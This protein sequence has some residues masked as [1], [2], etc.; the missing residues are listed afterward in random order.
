MNYTGTG[1]LLRLALRRDR[2]QL[3]VWIIALA[4]VL[5][6][7]ASSVTGL[8]QNEAERVSAQQGAAENA[9]ALVFNGLVS[10][11]SEGAT[12]MTQ[13]L[14]LLLVAA[15]LMSSLAVVRHTRQ[16]EE[17][18]RSELIGSSVVG[19]HAALTAAL[20]L[21]VLANV[22]LALVSALALIGSGLPAD[23][24]LAAGFAI[25]AVGIVFAGVAAVT[26]QIWQSARAANG[27]A[28]AFL[29]LAFLLR[30]VG[31]AAGSVSENGTRVSSS[32]PSWL[33]PIGWGQQIRPY[34][35]NAWWVLVLPLVAF[36]V[37]V[38]AAFA[39]TKVRD[40]GMGLRPVRP[41]PPR[42]APSLLSP[43][44]LAW[45]LQR[46]ALLGW[47]V[48]IAI[49]GF[50]FGAVGDEINDLVGE[51]ERTAEVIEQLGG[52]GSLVDSYLS[53]TAG[54]LGLAI[55][56]YAV[57]VLNR[58]RSEEAMGGLESLL[59]TAVSRFQWLGSQLASATVG[60]V[61][62]T[63]LAGLST[64]LG[65]GLASGDLGSAL[66]DLTNAALVRLPAVLVLAG[67]AVAAFGMLPRL[68]VALPWTV[69]AICLL[70]SQVGAALELPQSVM[71]ISPFTH[72]PQMPS[73]GF[74]AGAVLVLLVIAA[75]LMAGG[76]VLFRRR[77]L[78]I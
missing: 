48:G 26:A 65:Y 4:L 63:L 51:S 19:R 31:D 22:V 42:A 15:A 47:A 38:A 57:Q 72:V 61:A 45:R 36:A 27:G 28:A 17:T 43:F 35:D 75:V 25:G 46:G 10:G 24:S 73:V 52:A 29:G 50:S 58:M 23:G 34:D 8:Y 13:A 54:L 56:A 7:T 78:S 39:L 77:N 2:I 49:M 68:A 16:N 11:T 18:G 3:P 1:D 41:G 71:D 67:V 33:S 60:A 53:A 62:L 21:A 12:A 5:S 20:S 76:A 30:A 40:V 70:I 69:F 37:F 9:V 74:S 66:L 44:G 14:L 6:S 64:G 32:W 59:A 55:A